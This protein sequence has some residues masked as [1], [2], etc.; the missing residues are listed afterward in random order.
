M[1]APQ[2]DTP[3]FH[4]LLIEDQAD[5]AELIRRACAAHPE[6]FRFTVVDTLERARGHL[7]E[8]P[9][10]DLIIVDLMLPDGRGTALLQDESIARRFPVVILTGQG[11]EKIAVAAIK[12]GALDYIVKSPT[13]FRE[14]PRTALRAVREWRHITRRR[15][16][17]AALKRQL[18]FEENIAAISSQFVGVIDFDSVVNRSLEKIGV[19]TGSNRVHLALFSAQGAELER[20]YAWDAPDEQSLAEDLRALPAAEYTWSLAQIRGGQVVHVH[21]VSALPPG[22]QSE[23][24]ALERARVRACLRVPLWISGEIGGYLSIEDTSGPSQWQKEHITLMR[25][26]GE[27]I[28]NA[29]T[30][31]KGE[32]AEKSA[33]R[34]TEA[35]RET[36]AAL[37][38]ALDLGEVLENI[39]VY[40]EKVIPYVSAAVLLLEGEELQVMASRGFQDPEQ[41]VGKTYS[42]EKTLF[43]M[44]KAD[45]GPILLHDASVDPRAF[46]W[47]LPDWVRSWIGAQLSARGKIIGCLAIA[48]RE[49]GSYKESDAELAQTF[50]SQAT[51]AIENARLFEK[52][53]SLA[54]TDPLTSLFN[55]RYFYE[56][57]EIELKRVHRYERP[58]AAIM[59]DIDHFKRVNDRFGHSA[60][61]QVLIDVARRLSAVVRDT[62]VLARY[63][64]EEYVL[65]MPESTLQSAQEVAER[66]RRCIGQTPFNTSSGRVYITVSLGVAN[67]VSNGMSIDDLLK[68][69]DRALYQAKTHGRNQVR[70]WAEPH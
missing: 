39:L 36:M 31:K 58:L 24:R 56:L 27:I 26:T 59:M 8:N 47:E 52:I 33:R 37:T 57:A 48:C 70:V 53:Q 32:E 54:C 20:A 68:N 17:E 69:A 62:D 60:G 6:E 28:G 38:A 14:I 5:H 66:L 4:L 13:S 1:K 15:E 34:T 2:H 12:K 55:R 22:A 44:M 10:I 23:R 41:P 9:P 25:V 11:D 50:A 16:A 43:N 21:D 65:L 46:S 35:L 51:I 18:A 49:P 7:A 64:G 61:D 3:P 42:A 45:A 19:L 67:L 30:R 63:G 40:L 29:L